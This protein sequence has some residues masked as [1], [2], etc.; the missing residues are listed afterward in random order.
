VNKSLGSPITHLLRWIHWC[1]DSLLVLMLL[2]MILIAF[3]QIILRNF[4]DGGLIWGDALVR[5]LVIWVALTGAMVASRRNAHIAID[6]LSPWLHG[7]FLRFTRSISALFTAVVCGI[8]LYYSL[9]FVESERLD[10]S[11]AFAGIPTWVCESIIPIA[12]AVL[13]L[14]FILSFVLT[15]TPAWA[16]Y[17]EDTHAENNRP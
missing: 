14:R 16:S 8:M 15:L 12:F 10:G 3:A 4:F 7:G 17:A 11:I 9:E 1:E 5:I 13:T 6:L 2:T